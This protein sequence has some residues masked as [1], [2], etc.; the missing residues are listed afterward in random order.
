MVTVLDR[1]ARLG[2]DVSNS[3]PAA[4]IAAKTRGRG[5]RSNLAGRHEPF[6]RIA[7]DDGWNALESLPAFKTDVTLEAAKTIIT[8]NQ[9]PDISFDRSIKSLPRLRARLQLLLCPAHPRQHG[10]VARSGF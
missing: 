10:A 6:S 5:A 8:R 1:R 9:S 7:V 3:P 4:A 2:F